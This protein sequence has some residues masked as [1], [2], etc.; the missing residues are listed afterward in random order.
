MPKLIESAINSFQIEAAA[1]ANLS[2]QLTD[3][4]IKAVNLI[5]SNTGR[6]VVS[7]MGKSGII[8]TKIAATLN[9]TGTPAIFMHPVE[10]I[11]GDLGM[12]IDAEK[13]MHD[14]KIVSL[15][16]VSAEDKCKL[17]GIIQRYGIGI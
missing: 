15:L 17:E 5:K 9:S 13:K 6:V 8:G 7:G 12:L 16:V 3:D 2:C 1:I 14:N 4:F 11:H 10:A